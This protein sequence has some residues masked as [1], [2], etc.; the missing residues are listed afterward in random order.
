MKKNF[1]GG[2]LMLLVVL[3]LINLTLNGC[4]NQKVQSNKSGDVAG[5]SLY[6]PEGYQ[7]KLESLKLTEV[8]AM[9]YFKSPFISVAQDSNGTQFAVIFRESGEIDRVQ[10][11]VRY[12][13]IMNLIESK[14]Y[15]I[16]LS[17]NNKNLHLFEIKGNIVWNYAEGDKKLYLDK[18]G[19]EIDPFINK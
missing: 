7:K 17:E 18:E 1:K 2:V 13:E 16:K 12:V 6:V 15:K 14:G 3:A 8:V 9:P 4:S 5:D 11:P 19:K 10:L